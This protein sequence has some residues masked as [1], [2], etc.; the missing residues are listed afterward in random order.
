VFLISKKHA[1]LR[2]A[3]R[4]WNWRAVDRW[5]DNLL[6][7]PESV[8]ESISFSSEDAEDVLSVSSSFCSTHNVSAHSI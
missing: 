6:P 4:Y 7:S 8:N 3:K 5:I 1:Q 2:G